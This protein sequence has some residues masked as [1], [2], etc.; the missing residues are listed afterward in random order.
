MHKPRES[1]S[2]TT[3]RLDTLLKAL[4]CLGKV[5]QIAQAGATLLKHLG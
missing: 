3:G 5:L 1:R 2:V 4:N